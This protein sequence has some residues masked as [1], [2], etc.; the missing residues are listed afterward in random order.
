MDVA[1]NHLKMENLLTENWDLIIL[2]SPSE[3]GAT[4]KAPGAWK[5]PVLGS[6]RL[7]HV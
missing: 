3:V 7:E 2:S 6:V 4:R 1:E 5:Q